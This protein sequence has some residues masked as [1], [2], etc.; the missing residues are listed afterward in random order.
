M[1]FFSRFFGTPTRE[2]FARRVIQHLR[3]QTDEAITYDAATYSVS[4]GDGGSDRRMLHLGNFYTMFVRAE[5]RERD[6]F[7]VDMLARHSGNDEPLPETF[8][9]ARALLLPA[10]RS[11]CYQAF[12][13]LS[14]LANGMTLPDMAQR[15]YNSELALGLVIDAE[16]KMFAL[17][18]E[19]LDKWG[20]SYDEALEVATANLRATDWEFQSVAAGL[21]ASANGDCYDATRMLL[22]DGIAQLPV[23]GRP[24]IMVPNRN[25]LL[26]AGD[27]DP[28]ALI[29]MAQ[30]CA[31]Q[32]EEPQ[33]ISATPLVLS[34]GAWQPLALDAAH[35]AA[36]AMRVARL[37]HEA[38]LYAEQKTL[39]EAVAARNGDDVHIASYSVFRHETGALVSVAT[40][41]DGIPQLL[42][43]TEIL[44]LVRV[45]GDASKVLGYVRWTDALRVMEQ[46]FQ[47]T[48]DYPPRFGISDFPSTE[49]Q[50]A[51]H[52]QRDPMELLQLVAKDSAG[53][54]A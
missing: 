16:D 41:I 38:S 19:T 9:E 37:K 44:S 54:M 29:A 35:P 17:T 46:S 21:F 11:R 13:R 3:G 25:A 10:M 1:G 18:T 52:L 33:S 34:E 5:R 8:D 12:S 14:G 6:A 28:D 4:I 47:P 48:G 42:P 36:H 22:L 39:L 23:R 27:M 32:I 26:V 15:P 49:Q 43:R 53:A 30:L 31:E 7:I 50:L 40:W 2:D 51:M 45:A 20:V 24:V